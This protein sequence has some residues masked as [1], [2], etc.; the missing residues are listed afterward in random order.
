MVIESDWLFELVWN[1]LRVSLESVELLHVGALASLLLAVFFFL[2]LLEL[3]HSTIVPQMTFQLLH[4]TVFHILVQGISLAKVL[5]ELPQ[6][7]AFFDANAAR[8]KL[9]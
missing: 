5:G 8:S 4:K 6:I 3:L 9:E 1:L 2:D 7:I